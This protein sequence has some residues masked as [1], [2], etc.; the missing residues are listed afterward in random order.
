MGFG[1]PPPGER[2]ETLREILFLIAMLALWTAVETLFFGVMWAIL[3]GVF[4][5]YLLT[6]AIAALEYLSSR[7]AAGMAARLLFLL[8]AIGALLVLWHLLALGSP[9]EFRV[10]Y[11]RADAWLTAPGSIAVI[12]GYFIRGHQRDGLTKQRHAS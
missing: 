10:L 1:S 2:I 5:G 7:L 3:V 4:C 6:F 11:Y 12:I 8:F 9:P